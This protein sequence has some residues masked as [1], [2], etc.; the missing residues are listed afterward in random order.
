MEYGADINLKSQGFTPLHLAV[1]HNYENIIDLLLRNGAQVNEVS[2]SGDSAMH[3]AVQV[4]KGMHVIFLLLEKDV[5]LNIVNNNNQTP[6]MLSPDWWLLFLFKKLSKSCYD[7][8]I[9][10]CP[11]NIEFLRSINQLDRFEG[12]MKELKKMKHHV[13]YKG[14]TLLGI[15]YNMPEKSK[16]L[17]YLTKNENFVAKYW[18]SW[19]RELYKNYSDDLDKVFRSAVQRRDVLQMEE[20]KLQ[21]IFKGTLPELVI[22]KIAFFNKE[23]L[24]FKNQ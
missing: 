24:F 8:N 14:I 19:N 7:K 22:D 4:K 2:P 11:E 1:M 17:T 15:L 20:K 9:P 21:S 5:D 3:Y 12:Y 16:K 13:V 10:A 23:R 6:L 18:T